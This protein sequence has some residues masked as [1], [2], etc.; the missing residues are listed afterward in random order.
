MNLQLLEFL[1]TSSSMSKS[2]EQYRSL[3]PIQ[4]KAI[5]SMFRYYD[6]DLNGKIT[7]ERAQKILSRIGVEHI[8]VGLL[9]HIV[10]LKEL[11]E[12][13]D[14]H[15][16]D[17]DPPLQS[18]LISFVRLVAKPIEISQGIGDKKSAVVM[19]NMN[20]VRPKNI[21]D[22]YESTDQPIPNSE[23]V[24]NHLITSMVDWDDCNEVPSVTP[25]VFMRD[26][27]KF[28]KKT[29]ALRDFI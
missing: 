18:E 9:H 8:N 24:V 20:Y 15:L 5:Q 17:P 4:V 22:F 29:N 11:L 25:A 28:A 23:G 26:L 7:R 19:S 6:L 13:I 16:P 21:I 10:N 2:S 3:T 27:T 1:E 12:F 14:H